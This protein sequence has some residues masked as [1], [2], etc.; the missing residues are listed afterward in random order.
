MIKNRIDDK[1]SNYRQVKQPQ[2]PI[3]PV[4]MVTKESKKLLTL[5]FRRHHPPRI[6]S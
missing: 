5:I 2:K 3:T 4:I 6:Q 1:K